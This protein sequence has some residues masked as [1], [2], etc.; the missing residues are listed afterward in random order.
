MKNAVGKALS[1]LEKL[2]KLKRD[3]KTDEFNLQAIV[4]EAK[5]IKA[6]DPKNYLYVMGAVEC[7]RG[8][9]VEMRKHYQA[10]LEAFGG[11]IITYYNFASSLYSLGCLTEAQ[12]YAEKGLRLAPT[13]EEM[14]E[15]MGDILSD[16]DRQMWDEMEIETEEDLS[17]HALYASESALAK[18]WDDPEEDEAWA[19]L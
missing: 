19:D 5:E 14:Q 18:T 9:D 13:N 4:R 1:L 6:E 16:L 2:S 15:L 3:G 7:L 10:V 11:D 17:R 8:N 12:H